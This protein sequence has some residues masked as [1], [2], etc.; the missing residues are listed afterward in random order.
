MRDADL[1]VVMEAGRA[2]EQGS[3]AMLM[4]AGG[5]YARLEQGRLESGGRIA[6]PLTQDSVGDRYPAGRP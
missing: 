1:I 6:D 3:H 4:A 5:L 2:V